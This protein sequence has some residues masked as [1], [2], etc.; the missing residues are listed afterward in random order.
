MS[1]QSEVVIVG[2]GQA[3]LALSYYLT[4]QGRPHVILDQAGIGATWRHGRWDSFTLVTPN[5]VNALPGEPERFDRT[6]P[7]GFLPRDAIVSR[8]EA[9]AASFGAPVR[10][11]VRVSAVRPRPAGGYLVETTAGPWEAEQVVVATGGFQISKVPAWAAD[12]PAG[13]TTLT[14]DAYRNP[15]ALPPGGV[16][17]V[18]SAQTGAQITEDLRLAGRPVWLAVGRAG[19]LARRYRG[20][21]IV[22][23][24]LD[25]GFFARPVARLAA[26]GDR[27]NALPH[28]TGARGGQTLNLHTFAAQGVTLLGH[29]QAAAGSRLTVAPDL[30][31]NMAR[32]DAIAVQFLNMVDAYIARAGVEAPLDPAVRAA[33]EATP[34]PPPEVAALDLAGAG[35]QTIIWA[36]GYGVDW[37]WVQAPV[38]GADG[39]PITERGVTAAP[40]LSFLGVPWLTT[41]RSG[42]LG[43]VGADAAHLAGAIAAQAEAARQA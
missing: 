16:L 27:F 29:V 24:L 33:E 32:A 38:F 23:W 6:D 5:S 3:G 35:I 18:G 7:G 11:G 43:G 2:A 28:L 22:D 9:Y 21:D 25:L 42:L 10:T 34:P 8:L 12:L 30:A 15:A 1:E 4:Q 40:G 26:P 39:Y 37:G 13:I 41:F 20:R 19:R 17:V 14:S 36:C 31:A